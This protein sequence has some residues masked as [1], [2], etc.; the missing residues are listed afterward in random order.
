MNA[1]YGRERK[2]K[3]ALPSTQTG[4]PSGVLHPLPLFRAPLQALRTENEGLC[5]ENE[6][7]C[8]ENEG[9]RVENE[10][11]RKDNE[12][13]STENERIKAVLQRLGLERLSQVRSVEHFWVHPGVPYVG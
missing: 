1:S 6:G 4:V 12:G 5:A 13:V 8:T 3:T 2:R 10:S 7:L 11:L 9:L